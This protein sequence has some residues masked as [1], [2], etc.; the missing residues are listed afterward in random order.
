MPDQSSEITS[1][2][3]E[4]YLGATVSINNNEAWI[5]PSVSTATTW[6]SIPTQE[7]IRAALDF[8]SQEILTPT[9]KETMELV[10]EN[11]KRAKGL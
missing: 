1:F 7:A 8:M 11:T 3:L 2:K 6:R 4:L 5:K 10:T 9:L